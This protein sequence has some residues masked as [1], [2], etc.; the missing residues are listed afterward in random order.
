MAHWITRKGKYVSLEESYRNAEGKP[1][2]RILR[3]LGIP[4]IDWQYTLKGDGKAFDEPPTVPAAPEPLSALPAGLHVGPVDPVPLEKDVVHAGSP[5]DA[6]LD[7]G[8]AEEHT[9][10]KGG[11]ADSNGD[12]DG[13]VG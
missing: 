11:E 4:S 3:Y 9:D 13:S 7:A 2:K 10:G 1:R 8:E 5:V 6:P 12:G